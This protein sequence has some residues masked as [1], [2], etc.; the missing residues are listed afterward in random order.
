MPRMLAVA[1][2]EERRRIYEAAAISLVYERKDDLTESVRASLAVGFWCV[3]EGRVSPACGKIPAPVGTGGV[4]AP[5]YAL[6]G[7]GETLPLV[8][9]KRTIGDGGRTVGDAGRPAR[10]GRRSEDLP[11]PD[12]DEGSPV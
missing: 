7:I 4:I 2:A 10:A 3:G 5:P 1:T 12:D 11:R 6:V 9:R 8:E